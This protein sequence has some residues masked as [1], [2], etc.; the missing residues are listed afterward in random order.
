MPRFRLGLHQI[1]QRL[2]RHALPVI[3]EAAP[4]GDAMDVAHDLALRQRHE[5]RQGQRDGIFD[6]PQDL[7]PP[8]LGL[9]ARLRAEIQ[10][11]P[12]LH[13]L[14]A[15]R[16]AV[17]VAEVGRPVSS[18]PSSAHCSLERISLSLILPVSSG[19]SSS[20]IMRIIRMSGAERYPF[21]RIS[22][23]LSRCQSRFFSVSRL[24]WTFLPLARPSSILAMPLGLK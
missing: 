16:Q 22:R 24:S 23:A 1:E 2:R 12:V 11:R 3:V 6:E 19:R 5:L 9:H 7:E 20:L 4:G 17:D 21:A 15:G 8:V 14:L 10:H 18:R 13:F